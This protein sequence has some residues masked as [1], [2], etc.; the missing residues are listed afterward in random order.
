MPR[1]SVDHI[2]YFDELGPAKIVQIYEPGSELRAIVVVDN[3]AC[4]A[5]GS[6]C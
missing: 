2:E 4:G 3:V 6:S 1:S 5:G